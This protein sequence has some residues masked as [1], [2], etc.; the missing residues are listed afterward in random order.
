MKR[1]AL[2]LLIHLLPTG[3][4]TAQ[5]PS[6]AGDSMDVF[7][8]AYMQEHRVPGI[9]VAILE[10]GRLV[11]ARGYGLANVEHSVPVT[12]ETIFQSG[13][14]GKQFTAAAVLLL[15]EDGLL[16][17]DD[18]ITRHLPEAPASWDRVTV[19][20]LLNHTGGLRAYDD[21][22]DLR[23]DYT[24]QELI[25]GAAER[26]VVFDP[27]TAWS[28][29]NTGYMVLG[30]LVSRLTGAHWSEFL[31]ERVFLPAGMETAR[32]IS[33]A[34]IV[35]HRSAGYRLEEGRLL[36]QE[37]V[38]PTMLSTGDGALYFSILDL[39]K[40]DQALHTDAVLSAESRHAMWQPTRLSDGTEV[41]YGFGWDVIGS[42]A[43][44]HV[45]HGGAWQ[46]FK[47][48]ILRY[49]DPAVTVAV[50]TNAAQANPQALAYGIAAAYRP[51]LVTPLPEPRPLTPD[52]ASGYAGSY[53]LPAGDTV[54]V[55]RG[56]EG[57]VLRMP[58]G[59][60]PLEFLG[61]DVFR[62]AER[63][64][65]WYDRVLRFERRDD[66]V[67]EAWLGP[68]GASHVRIRRVM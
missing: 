63:S 24:E 54:R 16:S 23:R 9:A 34:E 20:H 48:Y 62:L 33:E 12:A 49:A 35:P 50:L 1:L 4:A 8:T 27:G 36:N 19:R 3:A 57:L 68:L 59:P 39:V 61:N 18:A 15:A 65:H 31:R 11:K 25:R 6:A 7:V 46:G 67:V 45:G 32:V 43:V 38:S 41:G 37:W 17:L 44:H 56:E 42:P 40:W 21:G 66:E 5:S 55:E 29:S 28:Y 10:G 60:I 51:E 13:S 52:L 22:L 26:P 64:Q 30:A 47:T 53:L 58:W 14:L 2:L